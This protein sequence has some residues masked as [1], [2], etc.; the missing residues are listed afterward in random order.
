MFRIRYGIA[1]VCSGAAILIVQLA[2][3]RLLAPH[4]GQSIEVWGGLLG[5]VLGALAAGYLIGGACIDRWPSPVVGAAF[6]LAAAAWLSVLWVRGDRLTEWL[7][8]AVTH[9]GLAATVAA[10]ALCAPPT[11]ALATLSPAVLRLSAG[12]ATQ[13]G[14]LGGRLYALGTLGSIVASFATAFWLL[15]EWGVRTTLLVAAG[16]SGAAA[17]A[18]CAGHPRRATGVTMACLA[19]AACC[20]PFAP[21]PAPGVISER[22]SAYAH[23]RV[24]EQG[25]VRTLQIN[26][27]PQSAIDLD[28]PTRDVFVYSRALTLGPAAVGRSPR[29]IYMIG[30]G[31]GTLARRLHTLLPHA[32]QTVVEIDPDVVALARAYF[33]LPDARSLEVRVG[34][35]RDMLGAH[36]GRLDCIVV[37]AFTD[38]GIPFHL[39][40]REFVMLAKARL[41]PGGVVVMNLIGT[42]E[43]PESR[44]WRNVARTYADVFAQV[45]VF[46][47]RRGRAE[48]GAVLDPNERRNLILVAGTELPETA[49]LLR[50]ADAIVA[51]RPESI[52]SLL[53]A[54]I[55]PPAASV[56]T[57]DRA[58]TDGLDG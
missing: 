45:R 6:C 44:L 42:L 46:P 48:R 10:L 23:L 58:D 5:V 54:P 12:A 1:L 43:G 4:V 40:T 13:A 25:R 27:H 20:A 29:S 47:V 22:E 50:R 24:L 51:D 28:D 11:L 38:E 55:A 16:V 26:A 53:G 30:L 17:V 57:D 32:H 41:G 36:A 39:T 9:T 8:G 52:A 33:A 15:P 56:L 35:G 21:E 7:A 37:D 49:S 31:G 3:A 19:C 2:M 14:R 18:L 34:D